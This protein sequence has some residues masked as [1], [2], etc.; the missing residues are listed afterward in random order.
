MES[1]KRKRGE[2]FSALHSE[3]DSAQ[4]QEERHGQATTS[5]HG[6]S[7][8]AGSRELEEDDS[9]ISHKELEPEAGSSDETFDRCKEL[10]WASKGLIKIFRIIFGT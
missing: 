1:R 8:A 9:V 3:L 6:P 10:L 7:P 4:S 5:S 2:E